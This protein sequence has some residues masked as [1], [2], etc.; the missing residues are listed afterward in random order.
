MFKPRAAVA[1]VYIGPTSLPA[2][3]GEKVYNAGQHHLPMFHF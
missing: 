3:A 2:V 1:R